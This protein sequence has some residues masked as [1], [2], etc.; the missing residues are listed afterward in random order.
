MVKG[1]VKFCF[2]PDALCTRSLILYHRGGLS[3]FPLWWALFPVYRLLRNLKV[4]KRLPHF[5]IFLCHVSC[6]TVDFSNILEV[7]KGGGTL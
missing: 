3:Q 5:S 7:K 1:K 6:D 2:P 4:E